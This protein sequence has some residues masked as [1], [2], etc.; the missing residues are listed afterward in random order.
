MKFQIIQNDFSSP[1]LR[2]EVGQVGFRRQPLFL[3]YLLRIFGLLCLG[4]AAFCL[5]TVGMSLANPGITPW[6]YTLLTFIY[7]IPFIFLGLHYMNL[8]PSLRGGFILRNTFARRTE[9][10]SDSFIEHIGDRRSEYQYRELLEVWEGREAL[11]LFIKPRKFLILQKKDFAEG[12]LKSFRLFLQKKTG[13]AIRE[14]RMSGRKK[15]D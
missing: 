9:F 13:R 7:A 5:V 1:L 15:S 8:V 6:N 14:L 2:R 4:V 10:R 3:Q 12:E 11:Y